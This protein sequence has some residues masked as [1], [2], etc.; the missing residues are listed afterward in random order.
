MLWI[1]GLELRSRLIF[2]RWY[3]SALLNVVK[4]LYVVK[5][6]KLGMRVVRDAAWGEGR[7][8]KKNL[9][10][11][12]CAITAEGIGCKGAGASNPENERL[13]AASSCT[14]SRLKMT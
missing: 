14:F 6:R 4:C 8:R 1:S 10:G 2:T 11:D 12:G 3:A 9:G 7:I 13:S 5:Y